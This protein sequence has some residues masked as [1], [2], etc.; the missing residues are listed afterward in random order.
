MSHRHSKGEAAAPPND[1]PRSHHSKGHAKSDRAD[2]ATVFSKSSTHS[3]PTALASTIYA[4]GP[5][6]EF[7]LDTVSSTLWDE[8]FMKDLFHGGELLD[9]SMAKENESGMSTAHP[10]S[11]SANLT[12]YL[13]W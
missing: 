2:G 1:P 8:R 13:F 6:F 7:D 11:T 3:F 12:M 4:D 9:D 5:D 10:R